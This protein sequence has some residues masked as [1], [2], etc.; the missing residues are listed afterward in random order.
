MNLYVLAALRVS[1]LLI[2]LCGD[3]TFAITDSDN[4]RTGGNLIW[5]LKSPEPALFCEPAPIR[6][7]YHICKKIV[8]DPVPAATLVVSLLPIP[9]E[10]NV[11]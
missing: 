5:L 8:A 4:R 10:S 9:G 2:G 6:G 7:D 3:L 1:C 11:N